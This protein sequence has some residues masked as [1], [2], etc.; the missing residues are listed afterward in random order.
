M[1][2]KPNSQDNLTPWGHP[3]F[4]TE[5]SLQEAQEYFLRTHGKSAQ[6]IAE[7]RS[8][9]GVFKSHIRRKLNKKMGEDFRMYTGVQ[10]GESNGSSGKS[11]GIQGELEKINNLVYQKINPKEP[12]TS[13]IQTDL[14]ILNHPLGAIEV[15][16][17]MVKYFADLGKKYASISSNRREVLKSLLDEE[18][19]KWI[20]GMYYSMIFSENENTD[21][22]DEK[23]PSSGLLFIPLESQRISTPEKIVEIGDFLLNKATSTSSLRFPLCFYFTGYLRQIHFKIVPKMNRGKLDHA[24]E[25]ISKRTQDEPCEDILVAI[26]HLMNTKG[27]SMEAFEDV[28]KDEEEE[29][30]KFLPPEEAE[31]VAQF[32]EFGA[33]NIKSSIQKFLPNINPGEPQGENINSQM[34]SLMP[35][36]LI[37]RS[38]PASTAEKIIDFIPG[39]FLTLMKNRLANSARDDVGKQILDQVQSSIEQRMEKGETYQVFQRGKT[40]ELKQPA[41]EAQQKSPVARKDTGAAPASQETEPAKVQK[42]P[43]SESAPKEEL[44]EE[45]SSFVIPG[46]T[47]SERLIVSWQQNGTKIDL[48][49]LSPKEIISLSGLDTRFLIPWVVFALQTGQAFRIKPTKITKELITKCLNLLTEGVDKNTRGGFSGNDLEEMYSKIKNPSP[50]KML[51]AILEYIEALDY[52]LSGTFAGEINQLE[53][54]LGGNLGEFLI[55]PNQ[56]DFSSFLTEL[57]SEEKK[58]ISILNRVARLQ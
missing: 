18:L 29:A 9:Q 21:D 36:M 22:F 41:P 46:Q 39:P 32:N 48:V 16:F 19:F 50:C 52:S 38:Q 35:L 54:K 49:S 58:V 26:D 11:K 40:A 30:K 24:Y 43:E 31:Y 5:E 51:V 33:E 56:N 27:N 8:A 6:L 47:I 13:K 25:I 53:E 1:E 3:E 42:P 45:E 44:K 2:T 15:I 20:W 14:A 55:N 10:I 23:I 37:I 17:S 4:L 28:L 34:D 57:T 7:G 12:S